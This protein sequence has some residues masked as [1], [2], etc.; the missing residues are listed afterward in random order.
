VS[1][2]TAARGPRGTD[3]DPLKVEAEESKS[4]RTLLSDIY[5]VLIE[6]RDHLEEED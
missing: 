6:I 4:L 5:D 3:D 1:Q 2:T